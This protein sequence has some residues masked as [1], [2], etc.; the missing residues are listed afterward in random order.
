MA[1]ADANYKFTAVD[2]GSPGR[3]GDSGVWL[4]SP[5]RKVTLDSTK[6]PFEKKPCPIRI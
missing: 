2:I 1:I 4:R 6:F 3:N 5:L